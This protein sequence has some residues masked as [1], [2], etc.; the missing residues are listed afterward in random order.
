MTHFD[1]DEGTFDVLSVKKR[2]C[3]A[4]HALVQYLIKIGRYKPNMLYVGAHSDWSQVCLPSFIPKAAG[5]AVIAAAR[6]AL[7]PLLHRMIADEKKKASPET[8]KS[9]RS[10]MTITSKPL[11]TDSSPFPSTTRFAEPQG[12]EDSANP[13][14]PWPESRKR[15][16]PVSSPMSSPI[17]TKTKA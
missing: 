6:E 4:C 3:P 11:A 2:C 8:V 12:M 14:F 9:W 15:D 16:R 17:V 7:E 5:E 10:N 1:G 13:G